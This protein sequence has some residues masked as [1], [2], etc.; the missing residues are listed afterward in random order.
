MGRSCKRGKE[1]ARRDEEERRGE[2]D[3]DAPATSGRTSACGSWSRA[4]KKAR[5]RRRE[6]EC[7]EEQE[8]RSEAAVRSS[9]ASGPAAGSRAKSQSS[10]G[11]RRSERER[12]GGKRRTESFCV[13]QRASRARRRL[14][15][16][17][18]ELARARTFHRAA[19]SPTASMRRRSSWPRTPSP[20]LMRESAST[21]A[22]GAASRATSG[23][24]G[25]PG[26]ARQRREAQRRW[27]HAC[28][29]LLG[30]RSSPSRAQK[31]ARSTS[32]KDEAA[33]A[34]A[35]ADP[36]SD[37]RP[38]EASAEVEPP[39][40]R[41]ESTRHLLSSGGRVALV[42]LH[43]GRVSGGTEFRRRRRE[44]RDAPRLLSSPRRRAAS[45][46]CDCPIAPPPPSRP[47]CLSPSRRPRTQS[48]ARS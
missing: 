22:F 46:R 7:R 5:S 8:G 36:T 41:D 42:E 19:M 39:K 3:D 17:R 18:S 31:S 37:K 44:E 9:S 21:T 6:K 34:H 33:R 35:E 23:G 15:R 13:S 11:T 24:R 2:D 48:R 28:R 20:G 40:V 32:S 27:K 26:R 43:T 38:C 47:R 4:A 14:R 16:A 12:E 29:E 45:R 30:H 25:G 10:S 1:S